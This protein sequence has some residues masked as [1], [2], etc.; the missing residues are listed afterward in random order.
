MHLPAQRKASRGSAARAVRRAA[1]VGVIFARPVREA[2]LVVCMMPLM[3][4][5]RMH[6]LTGRHN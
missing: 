6:T 1:S 3:R 2:S 5:A 4:A